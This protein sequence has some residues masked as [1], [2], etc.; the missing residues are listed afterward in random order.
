MDMKKATANNITEAGHLEAS[1]AHGG[2]V[3]GHR[4]FQGVL[5]HAHVICRVSL[6][7]V[8]H[9]SASRVYAAWK[10]HTK[11]KIQFFQLVSNGETNARGRQVGHCSLSS[12]MCG[13]QKFNGYPIY[14]TIIA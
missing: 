4:W 13:F 8:Q 14:F 6:V 5:I 2:N 9:V 3:C 10:Y 7:L 1:P 12:K 11:K